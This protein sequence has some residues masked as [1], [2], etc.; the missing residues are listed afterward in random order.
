[1]KPKLVIFD[2]DG[3]LVD[4]ETP[5]NII[6]RQNLGRHGLQLSLAECEALFLGVGDEDVATKARTMG[7]V[8]PETW[9][10]DLITE[11]H[12]LLAKGVDLIAGIPVLLDRLDQAS[13]PFC[14][15]SNGRMDRMEITLG[16]NRLWERFQGRIFS[17]PALGML[18]PAPDLFLTAAKTL[19]FS[20]I[21]CVVI[22]DSLSGATAARHAGMRCL[23]YVPKGGA[24]KMATQNAT[25]FSSMSKV[26]S[27]LEL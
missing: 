26:P 19:E 17:G 20:P 14:V 15:A 10:Q 22:E 9:L 4:S 2:C 23:G 18:K 1:M 13:I 24:N 7:A 8:L 25:L 3:V 16:Q 27:L 5:S 6:L 21:D 12:I 11:T